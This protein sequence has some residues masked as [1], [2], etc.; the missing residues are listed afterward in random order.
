MPCYST[1]LLAKGKRVSAVAALS[2]E[3]VVDVMFVHS[4]VDGDTFANFTER[5]L[6]PHLLP[7]DGINHKYLTLPGLMLTA[8]TAR[9]LSQRAIL[10]LIAYL[11]LSF[12]VI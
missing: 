12:L 7:F 3:G 8:K 5:S 1:K 4:G 2:L 11:S 9:P 6:L 10:V